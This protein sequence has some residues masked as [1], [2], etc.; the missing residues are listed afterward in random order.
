MSGAS[1][2][3]GE[4]AWDELGASGTWAG[5]WGVPEGRAALL[6]LVSPPLTP[7]ASQTS[8]G[9]PSLP[10]P[11]SPPPCSRPALSPSRGAGLD[12]LGN[13]VRLLPELPCLWRGSR[14]AHSF[15]A[16]PQLR[17][18]VLPR[19]SHPRGAL[20][21]PC[22]PR[23]VPLCPWDAGMGRGAKESPWADSKHRGMGSVPKL[24]PQPSPRRK[25]S[26]R[27]TGWAQP[28]GLFG[29]ALEVWVLAKLQLRPCTP[30]SSSPS[31]APSPATSFRGL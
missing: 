25:P 3:L 29:A 13:L 8:P 14:L 27:L 2:V 26:T 9:S 15:P 11:A 1:W 12:A 5:Q 22:M 28:G 10:S 7:V 6:V 20:Q 4:Q 30:H 19:R 21:S 23:Y 17:E 24:G 31:H 16:L 18:H